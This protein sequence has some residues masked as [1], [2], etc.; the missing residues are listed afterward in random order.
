MLGAGKPPGNNQSLLKGKS[1][2]VNSH[3]STIFRNYSTSRYPFAK[4]YFVRGI[5]YF[6]VAYRLMRETYTMYIWAVNDRWSTS[7][8][9]LLFRAPNSRVALWPEIH[10]NSRPSEVD[11]LPFHLLYLPKLSA[12]AAYNIFFNTSRPKW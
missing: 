1:F 8:E 11:F 4:F 12:C 9:K 7:Y 2:V 3:S 10:G 5:S 6:V